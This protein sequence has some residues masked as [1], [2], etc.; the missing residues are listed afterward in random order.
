MLFQ[1]LTGVLPFRGDSMAELMYKIANEE[2]PDLRILRPDLPEALAQ[3][4]A[5]M[6]AKKP[7]ARYQ[8]GDHL[9]VELKAIAASLAGG[10]APE[11]AATPMPPIPPVQPI[12]TEKTM[13]FRHSGPQDDDS[14]KTVIMAF[15]KGPAATAFAQTQP[16][17]GA[18]VPASVLPGY[19]AGQKETAAPQFD[20]T[21][22]MNRP[23]VNPSP[24]G[25]GKTGQEP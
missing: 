17:F 7:D 14:D 16:G 21:S 18:T 24:D 23:G 1:M 15:D 9:A 5:R 2:A 8:D 4:L 11:R 20:K 6:L 10:P 13:A 12:V 22:V 19:D 25:G 3:V